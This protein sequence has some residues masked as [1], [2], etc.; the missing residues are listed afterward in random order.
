MLDQNYWKYSG[1]MI[2]F[3]LILTLL[4]PP[5]IPMLKLL[6]SYLYQILLILQIRDYIMLFSRKVMLLFMFSI[7]KMPSSLNTSLNLSE[8]LYM[9]DPNLKEL[10]AFHRC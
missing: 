4:L 7:N 8:K 5:L 9:R 2:K 6:G 10:Y 3:K 1:M